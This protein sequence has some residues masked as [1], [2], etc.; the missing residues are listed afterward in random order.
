MWAGLLTD[1][2]MYGVTERV[3]R[4]GENGKA[5]EVK[6]ADTAKAGYARVAGSVNDEVTHLGLRDTIRTVTAKQVETT[7]R[8]YTDKVEHDNIPQSWNGTGP[9]VRVLGV[10]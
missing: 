2:L 6:C 1:D 8:V 7:I 9:N 3:T 4:E 5:I 10:A